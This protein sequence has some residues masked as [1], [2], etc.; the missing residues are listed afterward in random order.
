MSTTVSPGTRAPHRQ[1]LPRQAPQR[2]VPR[3]DQP[4]RAEPE[5]RRARL[6]SDDPLRADRRRVDLRSRPRVDLRSRRRVDL[7]S[8]ELRSQDLRSQ[9]M[10]PQDLSPQDLRRGDVRPG[11]RRRPLSRRAAGPARDAGR[12]RPARR[13]AVRA[14]RQPRD[15]ALPTSR[16]RFI[17]LVLAMLGG[18][19]VCLLVINTTLAAASFRITNL[20]QENAQASQRAQE[21][22]QQVSTDQ[23][24]SS[25]QQRA[26][27]LGMRLQPTLNFIDLKTGR[28]YTDSGRVSGADA[29]PG[30]TP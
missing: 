28:R 1:A 17:V 29:V 26:L 14:A 20:Q 11:S 18:G 6:G 21:L 13:P 7:R 15:G 22:Q 19:L 25:I 8:Q 27:R 10:S 30:Y 24:A 4:R 3:L 23:S 16:T 12:P 9:D 5:P 2:Q